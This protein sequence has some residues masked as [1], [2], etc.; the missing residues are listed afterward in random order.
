MLEFA[1]WYFCMPT[2]AAMTSARRGGKA[3]HDQ[4]AIM[5]PNHEKKKTRPYL[6]K[7]LRIGIVSAF[8]LTGLTRGAFQKVVMSKPIVLAGLCDDEV[9]EPRVVEKATNEG[10]R[11]VARLKGG[12]SRRSEGKSMLLALR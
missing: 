9:D 5:K 8:L 10:A 12:F 11:S 6:L 1:I 3:Y 2:S 7:G 4:K